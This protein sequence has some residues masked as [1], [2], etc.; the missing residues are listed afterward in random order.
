MKRRKE[1]R[2][3]KDGIWRSR[4]F[5]KSIR[6][7]KKNRERESETER[8]TEGKNTFRKEIT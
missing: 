3:L 6:K 2:K 7:T 8:N 4:H 5:R 1:H